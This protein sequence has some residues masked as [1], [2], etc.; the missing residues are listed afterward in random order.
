MQISRDLVEVA[1]EIGA[2]K[3]DPERPFT[4]ASGYRMPVY[5]DNRLLLGSAAHRSLVAEGFRSLLDRLKA[6]VDVVAG[7]ATAGIAPATTLADLLKTPLIY[8]RPNPKTHGMENQVEGVLEK[9]QTAVVIEDLISTGN[10]ALKA[11]EAVRKAGGIVEH[12]LCVFSYG[13]QK[14]TDLF[15]KANCQIHPLL[16]FQSLL[17]QA[18]ESGS[19]SKEQIELLQSW[20]KDP[21]AWGERHG[22]PKA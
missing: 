4:W 3:I 16:T 5:N 12:C 10:S 21:F 15:H 22:F 6:R 17:D 1:L 9:G 14:S 11:V 13:F 19:L 18:Q 7:T 8:V 20:Q 2:I